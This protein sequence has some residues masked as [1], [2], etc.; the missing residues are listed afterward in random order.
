MER[1]NSSGPLFELPC[2][3]I[4]MKRLFI[5]MIS[6]SLVSGAIAQGKGK[7]QNKGNG[8][9]N[10]N[11]NTKVKIKHDDDHDNKTVK[12]KTNTNNNVN[13]S[14]V[15]S[16]VQAAF[17]SEYGNLG[18]V[19]WTKSRG[20]WTATGGAFGSSIA[21]YHANG[22][23]IDTRTYIPVAQAPQPVVIYRQRV[24]PSVTIGKILKID[25]PGSQDVY[26]VT[27]SNGQ[28]VYLNNSGTVISYVPK[29]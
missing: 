13:V 16:K 22:Q 2:K 14:G 10:G 27:R 5:A 7:G 29:Y 6:F 17:A 12:V 23:R 28:V 8:N 24:G 4:Y 18:N 9:G 3:T 15:P 21:T 19:R 1:A 26:Q 20:N 11:G 25:L